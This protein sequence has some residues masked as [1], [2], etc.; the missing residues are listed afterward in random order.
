MPVKPTTFVA[1]LRGI[2]VGGKNRLPMKDLVALFERAGARNV[3]HYIQ[4]G[5]VVFGAADGDRIAESVRRG[6]EDLHC[7]KVPLVLRTAPEMR[8]VLRANPFLDGPNA[9]ADPRLLHVAFLADKPAKERASL[10]DPQ[11]SPPDAFV[12]N[13]RD[14]YLRLPNGAARS[15]LTNAYFDTTLQT[16]STMRNWA[17][18]ERLVEMTGG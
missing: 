11:R 1:L 14:L 10:L 5:N 9:E 12:L 16:T 3:Q 8:A 7:L 15:K 2:N 13:G 17:T 18:V 6:I 4:S